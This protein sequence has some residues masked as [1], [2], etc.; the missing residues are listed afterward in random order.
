MF[1]KLQGM[2]NRA[3]QTEI[4]RAKR[5]MSF[6]TNLWGR[7]VIDKHEIL[8]EVLTM[9][10]AVPCFNQLFVEEVISGW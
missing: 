10:G 6:A 3:S 8:P 2:I 9:M 7:K 4:S 5:E 1:H